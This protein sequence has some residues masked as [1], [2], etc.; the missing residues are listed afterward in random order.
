[1][2]KKKWVC[3]ALSVMM[4]VSVILSGCGKKSDGGKTKEGKEAAGNELAGNPAAEAGN[5]LRYIC[6]A[7]PGVFNGI[8]YT[9]TYDQYICDMVF[10]RLLNYD[11]ETMDFKPELAESWEVDEENNT[12][13]MHIRKGVQIH[14]DL[15]ELTAE[16]VA[17]TL[18]MLCCPEYDGPRYSNFANIVGAAEYKSKTADTITGITLYTK[19]PED[20]LDVVY[21]DEEEDPYKITL[22]FAPFTTSNLHAMT[23]YI[24]P[25]AYYDVDSYDEFVALNLKPVG[26][27]PMVFNQYVIDQYVELDKNEN[28]WDGAPK[29][30]KVIY[31]CVSDDARIATMQSGAAD[32]CEVRNVDEDLVQ[33]DEMNFVTVDSVQG[34]TFAFIRFR[35]DQEL[36]QD[37]RIRQAL[38]YAFDR[39]G[40]VESYTGGR[41]TLTY[42]PA[43]KDAGAYPSEDEGMYPYDPDKAAE[44]LDEAGWKLNES[45]GYRYKDGKKLTLNYTGIS[46]NKNDS[47]KT[48]V[49]I[50]N[51]KAVGIEL[52]ATFYD[53]AT[54][55]DTVRT[56]D[57]THIY[58]YAWSMSP[59]NYQ[60]AVLFQ[61]G[62][63]LND[64]Q[65]DN[66]EYDTLLE[67]ARVE[68]DVDKSNELY[69]QCFHILNEDVPVI[70]MNDYTT[71][72]VINN[73]VKNVIVSTFLPWT[74][75]IKNIE[76]VQ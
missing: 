46:E 66:P 19:A 68:L 33:I 45:D 72:W 64:G 60:N 56:D 34:N 4:V 30:D 62:S 37:I 61:K 76:I 28:Y 1:M 51:Y 50:E 74:Y 70:Y 5:V 41:S 23:G 43:P 3:L 40:F 24:L 9:A 63:L 71:P 29:L 58:G 53:W 67:E 55:M 11:S 57:K 27:G 44:L 13:T 73:R 22:E 15:G 49:M 65:Y 48:A 59:D 10:N 47:M 20:P 6:T 69:K 14:N 36:M 18:Q 75:N 38:A 7:P 52:I 39:A 2:K 12:V 31:Q 42:A 25:R 16:D 21:S 54:Y 17:F 35:M 32:I 8:L 26:T